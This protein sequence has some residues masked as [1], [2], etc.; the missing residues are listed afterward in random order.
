ML[1][2]FL[3]G[4]CPLVAESCQGKDLAGGSQRIYMHRKAIACLLQVLSSAPRSAIYEDYKQIY[5]LVLA[6][7]GEAL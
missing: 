2:I 7:N 3:A 5:L 4:A 6:A 1:T